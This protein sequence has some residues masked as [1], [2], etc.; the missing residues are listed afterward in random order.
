[1]DRRLAMCS[2]VYANLCRFLR[3]CF[4]ISYC[5]YFWSR[6]LVG[7]VLLSRVPKSRHRLSRETFCKVKMKYWQ[8][9]KLGK[10]H[11]TRHFRKPHLYKSITI[12]PLCARKNLGYF[13]LRER[14]FIIYPMFNSC[15]TICKVHNIGVTMK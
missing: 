14:A 13:F 11:E 1:M 7:N 9:K 12:Y 8:T 5:V 3:R 6:D 10:N 15:L 2:I 4:C